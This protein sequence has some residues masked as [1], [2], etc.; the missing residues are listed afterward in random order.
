MLPRVKNIIIGG[1]ISVHILESVKWNGYWQKFVWRKGS[2]LI[3]NIMKKAEECN[4]AIHLPVDFVEGSEFSETAQHRVTENSIDPNWMGL[5][6]GPK[7]CEKFV[8]VLKCLIRSSDS[9]EWSHGC[10]WMGQFHMELL[11]FWRPLLMQRKKVA[12]QLLVEVI[13]LQLSQNGIVIQRLATSALGGAQ[14]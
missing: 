5:D 13:R 2:Q 9:L 14:V 12:S 6:I 7:S 4:V 1:G 10:F 3:S 11:L 8:H